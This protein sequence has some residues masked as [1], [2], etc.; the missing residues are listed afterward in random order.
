MHPQGGEKSIFIGLGWGGRVVNLRGLKSITNKKVITFRGRNRVHP[1]PP[2][3]PAARIL[4]T[5]MPLM[6]EEIGLVRDLAYT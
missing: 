5:P 2:P 3:P 1:L 4:S 6:K